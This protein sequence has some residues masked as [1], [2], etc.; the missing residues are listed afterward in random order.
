MAVFLH[1]LLTVVSLATRL[2]SLNSQHQPVESAWT[3]FALVSSQWRQKATKSSWHCIDPLKIKVTCKY[4]LLVLLFGH[5]NPPLIPR[6]SSFSSSYALIP[7]HS[8]C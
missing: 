2:Q 6:Y 8:C 5:L 3:Q 4:P 1:C 7:P